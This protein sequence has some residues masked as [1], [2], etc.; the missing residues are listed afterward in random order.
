MN[1]EII[2]FDEFDGS[3]L[4]EDDIAVIRAFEA[5]EVWSPGPSPCQT[6]DQS[7]MPEVPRACSPREDG[8][9]FLIFATEAEEE[10][11]SIR[12]ILDQ[13][14][15]D[16]P[17]KLALFVTLKR[18]GHKLHG[19]AGAAGFALIS[20]VADQIEL[21]AEGVS[22][23]TISAHVGIEAISAATTV[24]EACLQVITSVSE[25]LQVH[26]L[27]TS[28]AAIY[29]SLHIDLQQLERGRAAAGQVDA[30]TE[31]LLQSTSPIHV[32][33]RRFEHLAVCT[34]N[35]LC[36]LVRAGDQH[37]LIPFNQ[38][39]R[40]GNGQHEQTEVRYSLQELLGFPSGVNPELTAEPQRPIS[41][42]LSLLILCSG[43]ETMGG[44]TAGIV[45]DEVLGEQEYVVEPLSSYLQRPGIAGTTID[46]S[47][48]VVLA[49]DLLELIRFTRCK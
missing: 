8:E 46:G 40:I 21:I 41:Q 20:T 45:V 6:I 2:A 9:M 16:E 25:E 10:I 26:L 31:K 48:R 17:G 23:G 12:R 28:L 29:Q 18:A 22:C 4:S 5:M 35:V 49:V 24:L 32:D 33:G 19:T 34:G 7:A 39:Q 47:G 1:D 43:G 15:Q 3:E 27:L 13:L 30:R 36:F 44:G 37:L 42:R 38:I 11:S 14:A